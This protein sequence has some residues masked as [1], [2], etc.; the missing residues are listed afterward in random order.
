MARDRSGERVGRCQEK[1]LLPDP[2]GAI[3]VHLTAK[4][5]LEPCLFVKAFFF[6]FLIIINNSKL[7]SS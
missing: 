4:Q 6:F 2:M 3:V 7:L 5:V 1:L